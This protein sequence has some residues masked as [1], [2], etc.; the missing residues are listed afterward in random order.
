[1]PR[2][3]G[4]PHSLREGASGAVE[5]GIYYRG[6]TW[7]HV[8]ELVGKAMPTV[9]SGSGVEPGVTRGQPGGGQEERMDVDKTKHKLEVHLCHHLHPWSHGNHG[10]VGK[11]QWHDLHLHTEGGPGRGCSSLGP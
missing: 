3:S 1:M 7:P 8:G 2:Q 10:P 9:P 4:I 6:K 5:Q 11:A